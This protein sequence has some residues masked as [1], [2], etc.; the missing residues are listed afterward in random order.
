M[1]Y[2]LNEWIGKIFAVALIAGGLG[3]GL[4]Y[5]HSEYRQFHKDLRRSVQ[6]QQFEFE[7]EFATSSGLDQQLPLDPISFQNGQWTSNVPT[8]GSQD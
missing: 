3:Y 7:T 4:W 2:E 8:T 1:L 6:S 5:A